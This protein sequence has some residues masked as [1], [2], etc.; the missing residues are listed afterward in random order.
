[1]NEMILL[2]APSLLFSPVIII[3]PAVSVKV[4]VARFKLPPVYLAEAD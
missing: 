1:M 4:V 2:I 3:L